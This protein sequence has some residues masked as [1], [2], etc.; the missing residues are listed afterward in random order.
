MIRIPFLSFL[1]FASYERNNCFCRMTIDSL[2]NS[3]LFVLCDTEDLCVC[4]VTSSSGRRGRG[5]SEMEEERTNEK[6]SE[7]TNETT[8]V[9]L[10]VDND[11]K[12][13]FLDPKAS[14]NEQENERMKKGPPISSSVG[15]EIS[16]PLL[17]G[18]MEIVEPNSNGPRRVI[19]D[20]DTL[21]LEGS[22]RMK[23]RR[24]VKELKGK[25]NGGERS[26]SRSLQRMNLLKLAGL[27]GGLGRVKKLHNW[28]SFVQSHPPI[29]QFM[30][31]EMWSFR[32]IC[33]CLESLNLE[34]HFRETSGLPRVYGY[35]SDE[36]FMSKFQ[37]VKALVPRNDRISKELTFFLTCEKSLGKALSNICNVQVLLGKDELT[38]ENWELWCP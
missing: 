10:R 30:V 32:E 1:F 17:G 9:K 2:C 26:T 20:F 18:S 22:S 13:P 16:P 38:H 15:T 25:G 19:Y 8:S 23:R 37:R 24:K 4:D 14:S 12:R 28:F 3:I 34:K 31:S 27:V 6:E 33:K 35:E 29:K 21:I 7:E 36:E 11:D 5:I